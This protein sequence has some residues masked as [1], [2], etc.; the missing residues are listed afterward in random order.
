MLL[1]PL[2]FSAGAAENNG[3]Q[4]STSSWKD[5]VDSCCKDIVEKQVN[6]NS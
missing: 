5:I 6:V 2:L 4:A 1:S 3:G